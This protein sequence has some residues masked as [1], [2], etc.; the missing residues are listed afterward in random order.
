MVVAGARYSRAS[1]IRRR[2]PIGIRN[3]G[4]H[5]IYAAG[6]K[7]QLVESLSSRLNRWFRLKPPLLVPSSRVVRDLS[8]FP[9]Y[10]GLYCRENV[11]DTEAV[12]R[13][14]PIVPSFEMKAAPSRVWPRSN[15]GSR[16]QEEIPARRRTSQICSEGRKDRRHQS[17]HREF[18]GSRSTLSSSSG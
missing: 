8:I 14:L 17:P 10:C 13:A 12:A 15:D 9:N 5:Q 1:I 6:K 16:D 7:V 18:P 2:W 3:H 4:R 11:H